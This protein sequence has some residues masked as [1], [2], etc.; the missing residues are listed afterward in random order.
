MNS[1]KKATA[2]GLIAIVAWSTIV[3]FIRSV[4]EHFGAI[5]GGALIYSVASGILL[6]TRGFPDLRAHTFPRA[7]LFWGALMFV[8]YELC[9]ALSV[10]F[11]QNQQQTIE[12]AMVNYL[13]PTFTILA[14]VT[15]TQDR[16]SF[17]IVPGFLLSMGGIVLVLQD[18]DAQ[19]FAVFSSIAQNLQAN[20]R[21]YGL[22]FLGACLWAAYSTVTARTAN[23]ADGIT[24]F[25][26]LVALTLWIMYFVQGEATL[27]ASWLALGHLLLAAA[28]MGLGYAAWNVGILHGNIVLLA[29]ASYFIPVFSALFAAFWLR[30]PLPPL[31]WIGAGLVTLGS[32]VCWLS[33]Q[34]PKSTPSLA[35]TGD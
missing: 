21:S 3:A 31:F 18:A 8:A 12:V 27:N 29:G 19:G 4:S 24:L 30:A 14:A 22:A 26:M 1:E 17:W 23:G 13:W 15:F 35:D 5:G 10:G 25:F 33:V 28:A 32:T 34:R 6:I 9:L 11:A 7:Y 16:A 20:P 2:I